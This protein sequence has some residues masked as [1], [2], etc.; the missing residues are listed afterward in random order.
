MCNVVGIVLL[1]ISWN[2]HIIFV[3]IL[4]YNEMNLR[5]DNR[6]LNGRTTIKL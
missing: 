3:Y 1:I 2:F 6:L 5:E 4:L